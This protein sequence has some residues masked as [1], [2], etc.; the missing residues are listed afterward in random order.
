MVTPLQPVNYGSPLG[1]T[2][3]TGSQELIPANSSRRYAF[4]FNLGTE[5]VFLGI[6][7]TAE[8]DKGVVV[9]PSSHYEISSQR[10]NLTGEAVNVITAS[11]TSKVTA[12]EATK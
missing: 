10:D 11:G 12:Q 3:N 5:D 8:V 1:I 7:A 6:G 9:P 2:A 4:V